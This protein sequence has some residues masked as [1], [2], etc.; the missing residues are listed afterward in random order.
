MRQVWERADQMADV[1]ARESAATGNRSHF[2][3]SSQLVERARVVL[4]RMEQRLRNGQVAVDRSR[5]QVSASRELLDRLET[6]NTLIGQQAFD[7]AG[8]L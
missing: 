2:R 4:R 8:V 5:R 3:R 6:T 1:R 7:Q